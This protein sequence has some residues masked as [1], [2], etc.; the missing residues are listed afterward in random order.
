MSTVY[1]QLL[2]LGQR[3]VSLRPSQRH[4]LSLASSAAAGPS[5]PHHPPGGWSG[6]AV[7]EEEGLAADTQF[8]AF[9]QQTTIPMILSDN[10]HEEVPQI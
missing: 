6:E 8:H 7:V 3:C 4:S 2:L 1:A 10:N 9:A 5:S